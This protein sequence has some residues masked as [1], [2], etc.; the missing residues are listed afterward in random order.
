MLSKWLWRDKPV[1]TFETVTHIAATTRNGQ[2][3]YIMTQIEVSNRKKEMSFVT[4]YPQMVEL[5]KILKPIS[6]SWTIPFFFAMQTIL[7]AFYF[8]GFSFIYAINRKQYKSHQEVLCTGK[9]HIP[10]Q[11]L[12]RNDKKDVTLSLSFRAWNECCMNWSNRQLKL[13]SWDNCFRGVHVTGESWRQ[14]HIKFIS[15][16]WWKRIV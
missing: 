8:D 3:K 5:Y 7:T 10:P 4:F 15:F 9:V 12:V 2:R 1:F 13:T 16:Q 11:K 6:R 14:V